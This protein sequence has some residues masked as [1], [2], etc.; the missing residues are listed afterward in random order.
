MEPMNTIE[1]DFD[2]KLEI[3]INN[4]KPVN[5]TDLTVSLLDLSS[6]FQRFVESESSEDYDIS[7]ELLIKEVRSGSII[8][9]L[10]T[11]AAP[12]VPLLW[13]GGSLYQ[14]VSTSSNIIDW[15]LGKVNNPPQN[16]T[17]K[18]LQQW[19]NI[20][21]PVAKDAGSQLVIS[22]SDNATVINQLIVSSE[23]ANAAQNFINRKIVAMGEPA[24]HIHS[25][26]V[27]VWYQTKFDTNSETGDKAIVE[28]IRKNP[29]KVIFENN[30]VKEAMLHGHNNFN[31]QWH[32]LAYV[33]DIEVQTINGVPKL[34]K[35]LRYYEDYTFDPEE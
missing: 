6:Q 10:V 3:K 5:L 11:K 22:A 20:I 25:K 23:Q 33:V 2:K 35:I 1:I 29:T 27:L 4:E 9:E 16:L 31:K 15:F 26:K 19:K 17:K 32:E 14:W 18:D 13:Q 12:L 30:A 28:D 34:Y 24:D 21:E 8:V 7:S